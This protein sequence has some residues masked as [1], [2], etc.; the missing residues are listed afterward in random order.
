MKKALVK[1]NCN[2][3]TNRYKQKGGN[4]LGGVKKVI[5]TKKKPLE[6][7]LEGSSK[8]TTDK[9]GKRKDLGGK[10]VGTKF[11]ENNWG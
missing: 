4:T 11:R 6:G 10:R 8:A 1:K 7:Q 5:K 9:R 2:L 3:N